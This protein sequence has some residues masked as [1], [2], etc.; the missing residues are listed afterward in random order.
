M[1]AP[2]SIKRYRAIREAIVRERKA[3]RCRKRAAKVF[4]VGLAAVLWGTAVFFVVT[5]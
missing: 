4:V 1:Y 2:G 3:K 5:L